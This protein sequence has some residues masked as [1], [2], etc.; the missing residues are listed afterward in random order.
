MMEQ[1]TFNVEL[2]EVKPQGSWVYVWTDAAT[3][4]IAYIGAT[5]FEPELRAHVHMTHPDPRMGRVKNEVANSAHRS[6]VVRAFGVPENM[7]RAEVKAALQANLLR[8]ADVS[9]APVSDF[10]AQIIHTLRSEGTTS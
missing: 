5:A 2:G 6:F 7:N 3:S 1:R 4:E 8:G 10:V 9:G